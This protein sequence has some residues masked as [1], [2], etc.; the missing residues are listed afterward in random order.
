M[1]DQHASPSSEQP[2]RIGCLPVLFAL[3]VLIADAARFM[4]SLLTAGIPERSLTDTYWT[5]GLTALFAGILWLLRWQTRNTRQQAIYATW[6]AALIL[7]VFLIPTTWFLPVEFQ[8]AAL[9]RLALL[10][11]FALLVRWMTN[12]LPRRLP[13]TALTGAIAAGALLAYPWLLWGALGSITDS[14]LAILAAAL[15][16]WSAARIVAHFW[17]SSSPTVS[18]S[19]GGF[20]IAVALLLMVRNL[21]FNNGS[22]LL[23]LGMPLL[24]WL[25]MVLVST[26]AADQRQAATNWSA[27]AVLLGF[28]AAYPL[29]LADPD[30]LP[31]IFIIQREGLLWGIQAALVM[32]GIGLILALLTGL[33]RRGSKRT[34]FAATAAIL[35]LVGIVLYGAVGQPGI[36]GD[37]L[38]VILNEQADVS[39]ATQIDDYDARR[40]TVY[41]TL[42]EH[43]LA[44]QADL[45]GTLDRFGID[46]TPYYL[47]NALE[48]EGNALIGLWLAGH[49]AVDRVLPSP[50]LRPLPGEAVS[51]IDSSEDQ[52]LSPPWNLERIEAPRTWTELGVRGEGIV[53][54][55]SDSGVDW[56]H[57]ALIDG[58]RGLRTNGVDHNTNWFDPW[59]GTAEP[60]D[61]FGHGTHTLGTAL[62]EIVGVA[63]DA[64]WFACRNLAR[65]VGNPALYL[66]CMQFM[67]APFPLNGDPFVDGD[68]TRSAHV[69]NNSWGCPQGMEGC[70]PLSLQP[71]ADALRAAGI[72]TVVSAGN[73]GP[74]CST[75]DAPLA[76]YESVF[77]VGA[78]GSIG[79]LASFSSVG[80]VTV[81]GSGRM[82]PDLVA[83]GVDILSTDPNGGYSRADG[84]S[85]AGPHV[86][87]VVTLMW[88][89]NP[90]LI[91]DI[92]RTEQILLETATPFMGAVD[93]DEVLFGDLCHQNA[94]IVPNILAGYG[95]VNAYRAV[96]RALAE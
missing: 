63:P 26:V 25:G 16:G 44:T 92:E 55:Q 51:L 57:P 95:I 61:V 31:M 2:E 90:A 3:F 87:G 27:L 21:G 40:T 48:V 20:V 19:G 64:S 6:L 34:L 85:S 36:Y 67:L 46:Y 80:P 65:N 96:E 37:R 5:L 47:V 7:P 15:F 75:I 77:T 14:V 59:A 79:N 70:D 56:N 41:R 93:P 88:S 42:I 76:L 74:E 60:V 53:I 94:Q 17:L 30:T 24:G 62:G 71:A 69:T 50:V 58:Y 89:A 78:I 28:A 32:G 29:L 52:P 54:G 13:P 4:A 33:M 10:G 84:T 38:F 9:T 39:A 86:A 43:A 91:G 12:G 82:K 81:D 68:P 23:A 18:V 73:E 11:I 49:P 83:P 22:L 8:W 35:W 1:N 72:F 66:D 45:R